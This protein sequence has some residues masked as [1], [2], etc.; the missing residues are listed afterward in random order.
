MKS[1]L[2]FYTPEYF[3]Y[4][5]SFLNSFGRI[6]TMKAVVKSSYLLDSMIQSWFHKKIWTQ[7]VSGSQT[8]GIFTVISN[9]VL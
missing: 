8:K 3:K 5:K 6:K 9:E 1:H 7:S 2:N 4:F